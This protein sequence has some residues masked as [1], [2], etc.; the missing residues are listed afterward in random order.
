VKDLTNLLR[1]PSTR[2]GTRI[3]FDALLRSNS[4][5]LRGYDSGEFNGAVAAFV[6]RPMWAWESK[7]RA[8][9]SWTLCP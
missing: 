2:S 7:P 4:L 9:S 3:L 5:I 8:S 1:E 6:L